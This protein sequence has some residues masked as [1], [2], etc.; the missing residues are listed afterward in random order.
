MV[1]KPGKSGVGPRATQHR[2]NTRK[3]QVNK[4]QRETIK[5]TALMNRLTNHV[6]GK[7]KME[8][9]QV[10]AANIV[11]RKALP[12]LQASEIT[13]KGDSTAQTIINILKGIDDAKA[14]E[15]AAGVEI[16]DSKA[17]PDPAA[18]H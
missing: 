2:P 11:L 16:S 4:F 18:I 12:D 10:A 6:L 1:G 7:V 3:A 17:K 8:S 13:N 14:R 5:T 15:T 9:S